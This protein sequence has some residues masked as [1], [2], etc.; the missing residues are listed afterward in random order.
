MKP[1]LARLETPSFCPT[2]W[3]WD[4]QTSRRPAHDLP[5]ARFFSMRSRACPL[6][7]KAESDGSDKDRRSGRGRNCQIKEHS[8]EARET[9]EATRVR[10]SSST[11]RQTLRVRH[12]AHLRESPCSQGRGRR[13]E[14]AA[15]AVPVPRT[16]S[17][18]PAWGLALNIHL[19]MML[20]PTRPPACSTRDSSG[21]IFF[22]HAPAAHK[23][24]G[25]GVW[26][27]LGIARG[28]PPRGCQEERTP[29]STMMAQHP[30]LRSILSCT[31]A[32]QQTQRKVTCTSINAL[33]R[34]TST[35]SPGFGA[36]RHS[37]SP[38]EVVE[39]YLPVLLLQAR[40][41]ARAR[42]EICRHVRAG[43]LS[44]GDTGNP[45]AMPS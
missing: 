2:Y 11:S 34:E 10:G 26:K 31:R 30:R 3:Y 9:T 1:V 39:H 15:G 42:L 43:R 44:H 5:C 33:S 8:R 32:A 41:L 16:P 28:K 45:G 35:S 27:Q 37:T 25:G 21:T 38:R 4:A 13:L 22:R 6:Q 36:G 7:S 20:V 29:C 23:G 18:L 19:D 40:A 14:P 17:M 24:L 12:F